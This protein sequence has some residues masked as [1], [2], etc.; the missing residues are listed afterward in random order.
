MCDCNRRTF[1][2]LAGC[3]ALSLLAPAA[4]AQTIQHAPFVAAA[5]KMRAEAVAKGDQEYGAVI[6]RK[7][8]IVGYGP[9]RVITDNNLDAHA[10]RVALWDAKR[11]LGAAGVAG[12]VI[13]STSRPCTTCEAE[14][15]AAHI[16]RMYVGPEPRDIGKPQLF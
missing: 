1:V 10:E 16:A 9:S 2:A 11:R 4:R 3:G 6:V 7:N 8:V 15:A 13:Y 12:C 5:Q 14:L